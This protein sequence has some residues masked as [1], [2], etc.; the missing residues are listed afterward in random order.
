MFY[1]YLWLRE[2]GTP[3]Y[4]GK[5]SGRRAFMN[6]NHNVKRPEH[7]YLILVQEFPTEEDAFIAEVFLIA[8]YGR[9]DRKKG[10]LLNFSDGGES[11]TAGA[12]PWNKGLKHTEDTK[13]KIKETCKALEENIGTRVKGKPW[14]A[15]R[16]SAHISRKGIPWTAKRR[17][18]VITE[19]ARENM[20]LSHKGKPWSD[21]R[22]KRYEEG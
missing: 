17:A 18:V 22:R 1:T 6:E 13:R 16:R 5:G 4:V 3:Y 14:S 11:G 19:K 12:I 15:A 2:D 7:R 21:A 9:K 20:G 10:P 8:Y